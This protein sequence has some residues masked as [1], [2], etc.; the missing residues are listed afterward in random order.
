MRA[1]EVLNAGDAA[2]PDARTYRPDALLRALRIP[3]DT[4][5]APNVPRTD[6]GGGLTHP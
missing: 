1:P 2:M 4:A 5:L 6:D 3:A